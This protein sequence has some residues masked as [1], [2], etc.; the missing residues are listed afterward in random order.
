MIQIPGRRIL[1]ISLDNFL[2]VAAVAKDHIWVF[3]IGLAAF[4]VLMGVAATFIARLL[5]NSISWIAGS[6]YC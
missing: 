1:S 2:A 4:S 5:K 3:I 6:A